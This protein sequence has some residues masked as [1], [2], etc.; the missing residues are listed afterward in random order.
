MKKFF[1]ITVIFLI[2]VAVVVRFNFWSVLLLFITP[3][4]PFSPLSEE[5]KPDYAV[6]SSWLALPTQQDT[7][8][9][10]AIDDV[11]RQATAR[12]DVFFIHPTSYFGSQWNDPLD[13]TGEFFFKKERTMIGN[14]S[15]FNG[16]ARVYSPRHRQG[17]MANYGRETAISDPLN[18]AAQD[19]VRAFD[20]YM[21]HYN[22]GRPVIIAGHSQGADLG[23][24][25]LK[26]RFTG[27]P[28][29][30]KL[31]AAY[32]VGRPFVQEN[33]FISLPDIP[34]C[35]QPL[36]NKCLLSW[37]AFSKDADQN[38]AKDFKNKAVL[39][40]D[41]GL[42]IKATEEIVCVNPLSWQN[43]EIQVPAE[44][45]LGYYEFDED[46]NLLV[47]Q[48]IK[49]GAQCLDGLLVVD[50]APPPVWVIAPSYH[51]LD[52]RLFYKNIRRNITNRV[53][54]HFAIATN[55]KPKTTE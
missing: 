49:S 48:D 10:L 46:R 21:Q 29:L 11:D 33:I 9:T 45:N 27:K 44:K 13:G 4:F 3:S 15:I 40:S 32:L 23:L 19:V 37:N 8:D 51:H 34:I 43:N 52:Y 20:Y 50:P 47:S 16:A 18:F 1:A 55:I 36:Q 31:V 17:N 22:K 42:E 30:K 5:T 2:G 25:L 14:A 39:V 53:E 26:A 6:E 12:A 24:Y 28:I 38:D 35:E 41:R 54:A 7:S